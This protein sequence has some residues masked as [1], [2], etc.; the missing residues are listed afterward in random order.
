SR[1]YGDRRVGLTLCFLFIATLAVLSFMGTPW[2][3]VSSSPDQE[4]VAELLPQT[5]PGPLRETDFNA[6]PAGTYEAA[7][8]ASAP[9]PALGHLL[10]EYENALAKVPNSAACKKDAKNCLKDG[11]GFM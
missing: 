11:R 10:E 6:L 3:A 2:Y 9:T 5:H 7:N 4:V 8:W 1:R